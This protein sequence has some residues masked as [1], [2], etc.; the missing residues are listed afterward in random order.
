[1]SSVVLYI[2]L[3]LVYRVSIDSNK[4]GATLHIHR[5]QVSV[6]LELFCENIFQI[7]IY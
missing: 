1:M 5:I 2:I 4:D 7:I 6:R 3:V